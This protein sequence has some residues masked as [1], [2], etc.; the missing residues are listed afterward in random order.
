MNE[1]QMKAICKLQI[2]NG[3][4]QLS[5]EQKEI[6]KQAIDEARTVNELLNVITVYL[7]I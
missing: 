1:K 4:K 5:K 6:I 2:E 7:A 3:N